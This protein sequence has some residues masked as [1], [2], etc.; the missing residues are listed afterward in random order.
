MKLFALRIL[1]TLGVPLI[2]AAAQLRPTEVDPFFDCAQPKTDVQ[3]AICGNTTL[4]FEDQSLGG[5]YENLLN[6]LPESQNLR[7]RTPG[8]AAPG[9]PAFAA[10]R[11]IRC[12]PSRC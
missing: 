4:L 5:T 9:S 11:M 6:L 10:C 3:R 2:D 1:R 8:Q 12:E 7:K